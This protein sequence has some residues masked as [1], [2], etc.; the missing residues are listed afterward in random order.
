MAFRRRGS[1]LNFSSE[2]GSR[3]ILNITL[4]PTGADTHV[5]V[6]EANYR[7]R[8]IREIHSVV[9]GA[10]AVVRVRKITD[11]SGPGAAASSTVIEVNAASIDLTATTNTQVDS[12][13][14]PTLAT[15][16]LDVG[17]HLAVNYNGTL[18]GVVGIVTIFLDRE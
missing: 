4:D 5:F 11:T 13:L 1:R 14:V 17:D 18:T 7:V 2:P 16:Q 10:S 12:A 9:G 8:S 15:L 3:V 6:A